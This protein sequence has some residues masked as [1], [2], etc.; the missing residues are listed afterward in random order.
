MSLTPG[1]RLGSF[2]IT[3]ALGAGGMGEVYRARDTKLNREVALKIVPESFALDPDRVARFKREAQVLASLNHPNIGAIYGF[4]ESNGSQAL[5]L[6][7]VDG[8]TLADR[9]AQG[10]MPLD[11]ALP[12]AKQIAE[13]LEAAHE[14]GI[15]HRD[16]KPA[17]I[18]L[19]PDGTVKVLDFGL[20]KALA[21]D[22]LASP[23]SLTNSPTLTSPLN[24]TGVGVLLGT[25]AYMAPEQ[26]RGRA[27]DKRSDIWAFG[28]VLYEMLTGRRAFGGEDVSI[29]LAE[30]IRGD[31]DWAAVPT[32]VPPGI[33]RVLEQCLQKDARQRFRDIGDVRLALDG[34]FDVEVVR[35]PSNGAR[36]PW[37]RALPWTAAAM[38]SAL[39]GGVVWLTAI[40]TPAPLP[41]TRFAITPGSQLTDVAISPD[42]KTLAYVTAGQLFVRPIDRIDAVPFPTLGSIA[43]PF[44]SPDGSWV[45]YFANPT[46][47]R[48]VPVS[49]GPS[50]L[51][52][53]T[54]APGRGATWGPDGTIVLA[55]AAPSGLLRVSAEGG[56]PSQLTTPDQAQGEIDHVL[57]RFL[58]DGKTV[59]FTIL[60]SDS[61]SNQVAAI[62][63]ATG[64]RKVLVRGA[65]AGR[66]A[67]PGHLV[68]VRS[69][70]LQAVAFDPRRVEV[71]GEP[72]TI[73]ERVATVAGPQ[74]PPQVAVSN[75]GTLVYVPGSATGEQPRVLTW[76]DRDGREQPVGAETKSYSTPR[77]SKDGTRIVAATDEGDL[78]VYDI[79]RKVTFP[80]TFGNNRDIRPVWSSGG[81][82]VLFRTND[83]KGP[84]IY[85]LAADGSGSRERLISV[86]GDGSPNAMTPDGKTLVYSVVEQSAG[87][88]LWALDLETRETKSIIV[89]PGQQGN[90][91]ISPN[92]HWIAYDE[93]ESGYIYVHKFP[94][95]DGAGTWR[96]ADGGS[97]WPVWSQDGGEL[98]YVSTS[99]PSIMAVPVD[100]SG[101]S[102]RWGTAR[103]LFP[104][105]YAN[106][107]SSS[108]PRNYDVAPDGRFL[109]IKEG[110]NDRPPEPIIVVQNWS[111]ELKRLVPTNDISEAEL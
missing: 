42:G 101:T 106:F 64:S 12:I 96:L 67:P 89:R 5:V 3:G 53:G 16:L 24:V 44:F 86:S 31:V 105:P 55:T 28:C 36:S 20:A 80:L 104:S 81:S 23:A 22:P 66:Y 76:V 21:G 38:L 79:N 37:R 58:P 102:F 13:A 4:E 1:S 88:D 93:S 110:S 103:Q 48:R 39:T 83:A 27:V 73:L 43:Q 50:S 47:L 82:R 2:E 33:R 25:A 17:N 9:I 7:L 19:R 57:P 84:S 61:A 59:L 15:V 92:G 68:F 75:T 49:G 100:L 109:M 70:T 29:T 52:T 30:I 46:S 65:S 98:F 71:M 95:V 41:I 85:S 11:E 74:S 45:G 108:G 26:A 87:R 91:A 32:Q 34:A 18:K 14:Q 94:V 99:G 90:A 69:G 78:V 6:E 77:V 54:D 8:P 60:M 10:P 72:A 111:E 63:L 35:Q 40:P 97:K 62:D 56:T 51:I 107:N